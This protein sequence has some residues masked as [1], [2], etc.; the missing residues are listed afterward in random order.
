MALD[1]SLTLSSKDSSND[2]FGFG[3]E[4]EPLFCSNSFINS[5]LSNEL[6]NCLGGSDAFGGKDIFGN[7]DFSNIDLSLFADAS[8]VETIGSVAYAPVETMGSAAFVSTE[9]IGSVACDISG[10]AGFSSS[11]SDGGGSFSSFC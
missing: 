6:I 8:Q 11:C 7:P 3:S 10:D 5:V 2:F 9:T 4:S 1:F